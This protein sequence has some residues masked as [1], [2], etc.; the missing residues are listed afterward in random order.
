MR[1]GGA[2]E[3]RRGQAEELGQDVASPGDQLEQLGPS[4][5]YGA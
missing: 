2:S 3:R 1:E 5:R 4:G